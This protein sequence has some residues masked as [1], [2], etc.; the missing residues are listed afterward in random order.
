MLVNE[1]G[2]VPESEQPNQLPF[3]LTLNSARH[4]LFCLLNETPLCFDD[5]P[6]ARFATVLTAFA[7]PLL[8]V[9]LR[10]LAGPPFVVMLTEGGCARDRGGLEAAA[11]A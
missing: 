1:K 9:V 7:S 5:A 6:D 8:A 3:R 2:G 11:A 4:L 10:F